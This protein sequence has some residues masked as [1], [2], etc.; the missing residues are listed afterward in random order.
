MKIND[1]EKS[2]IKHEQI[3]AS[4]NSYSCLQYIGTKEIVERFE[5][6]CYI[7]SHF[8]MKLNQTNCFLNFQVFK[9]SYVMHEHSRKTFISIFS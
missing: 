2:V 6:I 8:S 7:R 9:L 5:H 3:I 4:F 1:A